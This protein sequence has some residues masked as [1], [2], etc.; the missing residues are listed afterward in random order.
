MNQPGKICC[1][2]EMLLRFSPAANG[3]WLHTNQ[4][5]VFPGGAELNVATA[6]ANWQLP[7]DYCTVLPDNAIAQD[8]LQ[9]LRQHSIGTNSVCLAGD[10]IGTYY[11]PQGADL[12]NAGV[13]YDRAGSSFAGLKTGQ[14][15]WDNILEGCNWFHFTA[16]SPAL[17]EHTAAVCLEAVTAAK[18]KGITVSVDL[19]Y[20]A[21]LWKYGKAPVEV[22][23]ALVQHCDVIMGNSWAA[24]Q[25]LGIPSPLADSKGATAAELEAAAKN[26]IS[27]LRKQYPAAHTIA[28]TFRLDEIYFAV[29]N[30]H[31]KL[32]TSA[33]YPLNE[34][35]DKAGSGDCFMAGIIY[36]LQKKQS[37]DQV[38][39]FAAAAAVGKMKEKGDATRQTVEDINKI[40]QHVWI[41]K[42]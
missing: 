30:N 34:V 20:R 2:G 36:G 7:V 29:L 6:L 19:N 4:L 17:N 28:Y 25:L 32:V 35:T 23:P 27:L 26:S 37:D 42:N 14:L 18:Q 41:A 33:I 8:I 22:M 39:N 10:R 21:K 11:L 9:Y 3:A 16:I 1:F 40:F 24:E 15:N 38:V 13:I 12:K 5:A 31:E